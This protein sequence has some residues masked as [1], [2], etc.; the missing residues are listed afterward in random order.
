MSAFKGEQSALLMGS[1]LE[2]S[3]TWVDGDASCFSMLFFPIRAA[4]ISETSR[5]LSTFE[6]EQI[7]KEISRARLV[8]LSPTSYVFS[9]GV[10]EI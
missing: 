9:Q 2:F 3:V 4:L 10:E 6:C 8:C 1:K 5:S 7:R